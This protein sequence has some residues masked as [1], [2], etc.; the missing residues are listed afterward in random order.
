LSSIRLWTNC[1][2]PVTNQSQRSFLQAFE[3]IGCRAD[4]LGASYAMAENVFAVTQSRNSVDALLEVSKE[5]LTRHAVSAPQSAEDTRVLV[6]C[7]SPIE[8]VSIKIVEPGTDVQSTS[9]VGEIAI[10]S[11]FLFTEYWKNPAATSAAFTSDGYYRTGDAG[12][13]K[14]N[15][16]YVT[17]RLKDIIIIQGKNLHAGDIEAC[18]SGIEGIIP[19]RVVALGLMDEAMGSE[20]LAILAET[21]VDDDAAKKLITNK[22]RTQITNELTVSAS[23]IRLMP[24]R[25]LIKST[26]GKMARNENKEKLMRLIEAKHV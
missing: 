4:S 5:G 1:S 14:D 7:G 26:S 21:E 16:I 10:K 8:G 3:K 22:I 12:F 23:I 17:G 18:L 19:G 2:E 15:Q 9:A 6:G 20:R 25:W 24:P 13:I 11:E